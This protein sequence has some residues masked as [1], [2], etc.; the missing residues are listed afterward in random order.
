MT[1]R[2]NHLDRDTGPHSQ[3]KKDRRDEA[4]AMDKGHT[5]MHRKYDDVV[6]RC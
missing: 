1:I 4:A 5:H 2:M 6:T 3:S